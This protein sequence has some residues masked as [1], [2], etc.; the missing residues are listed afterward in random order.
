MSR[1]GQQVSPPSYILFLQVSIPSCCSHSR[2]VS[3]FAG[4][5]ATAASL[6]VLAFLLWL[7]LLLL[8]ASLLLLA[9]LLL[10]AYL[11]LMESLLWYV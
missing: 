2:A 10:L 7:A 11:L 6:L 4:F 9:L 5:L 3:G 1:R 8:Q